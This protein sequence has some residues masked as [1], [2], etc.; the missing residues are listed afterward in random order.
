VSAHNPDDI[1]HQTAAIT[2]SLKRSGGCN[3]GVTVRGEMERR[4]PRSSRRSQE[5]GA[6]MSDC[7]QSERRISNWTLATGTSPG[8]RHV[9]PANAVKSERRSAADDKS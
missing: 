9:Y 8:A 5:E 1:E 2:D 4:E 7:N 6:I 3:G